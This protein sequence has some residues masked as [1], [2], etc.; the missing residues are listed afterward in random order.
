M[1]ITFEQRT[2]VTEPECRKWLRLIRGIFAEP[3]LPLVLSYR[4]TKLL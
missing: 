2:E 1:Y 3:E 4:S